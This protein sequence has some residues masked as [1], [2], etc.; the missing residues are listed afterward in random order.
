MQH[1]RYSSVVAIA[2]RDR[3]KA[4]DAA[5][6]LGIPRSY[7]SY[8]LLLADPEIDAI[9]NPLPNHLHVPW[10]IRAAQAGKHVLC[11]KPISLNLAE[12]KSLLAARD[13][14]GVRIG[15]AFMVRST[16]QWQR[17]RELIVEGRIGEL[18]SVLGEFSYYNTDPA[19]IRNRVEYG[20]GA[21]L[22]LGCYLIQA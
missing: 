13:R 9:Y 8:E 20:G 2:S 22:D 18:R 15:E 5:A 11:E 1:G 3:Q 7:G 10:S 17:A 4:R 12:A 6:S 19:N 21:L 14:T 16:P